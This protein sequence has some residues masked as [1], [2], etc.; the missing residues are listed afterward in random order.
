ML[1]FTKIKMTV[2]VLSACNLN[3]IRTI[4]EANC[5]LLKTHDTMN[6]LF[7]AIIAHEKSC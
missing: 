1:A 4:K 2:R 5:F 3:Q 7:F 6:S